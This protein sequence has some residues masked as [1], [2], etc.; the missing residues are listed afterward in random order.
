MRS[1]RTAF[2]GGMVRGGQNHFRCTAPIGQGFLRRRGSCKHGSHAWDNFAWNLGPLQRL[3]FL[4]GTSEDQWIAALESDHARPALRL[5]N[6]YR[7][8]LYLGDAPIT[9]AFSNTDQARLRSG[10]VE[11]RLRNQ[12]VVLDHIGGCQQTG[13]LQR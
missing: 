1:V 11:N 3:D 2:A 10:K 8:N 13:S 4:S 7:M 6:H 9:A 12:I 5:L